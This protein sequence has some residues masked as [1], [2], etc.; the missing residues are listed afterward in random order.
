[1][2]ARPALT[3]LEQLLTHLT[4]GELLRFV[5]GPLVVLQILMVAFYILWVTRTWPQIPRREAILYAP[6]GIP[7]S[8]VCFFVATGLISATTPSD[9]A[10]LLALIVLVTW[11][12][13]I[14]VAVLAYRAVTRRR[15][16]PRPAVDD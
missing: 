11:L 6:L 1:M 12:P 9:Y 7:L 3:M 14:P 2:D 16:R 4:L 15:S 13:G 8:F 10:G 5:V